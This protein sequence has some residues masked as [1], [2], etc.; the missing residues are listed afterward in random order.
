MERLIRKLLPTPERRIE[1]D[2]CGNFRFVDGSEVVE[3]GKI[4][5]GVEPATRITIY[6]IMLNAPIVGIGKSG[7]ETQA[8]RIERAKEP[9][10]KAKRALRHDSIDVGKL[11]RAKSF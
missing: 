11:I 2:W 6:S 5:P 1:V 7:N 3:L 10:R 9:I 8:S 4:R